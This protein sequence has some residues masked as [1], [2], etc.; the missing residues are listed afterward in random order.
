MADFDW[1]SA[2]K[3]ASQGFDWGSAA[4]A[5]PKRE[6]TGVGEALAK[7]TGQ[8]ITGGFGDEI[9]G[10]V[11]ALGARFLPESMGGGGDQAE[12]K[13]LLELY[14]QNRNTFREED[15]LAEHD[16][17]AAF[18]VGNIAGGAA[19]TPL[20][21]GGSASGLRALVKTG[22]LMGGANGL[23]TSG[24]DL[25][26]GEVGRAAFDTAVGAGVGAGAGAAGYGLQ[27]TLAGAGNRLA[28]GGA[29]RMAAAETK[30]TEMGEAQALEEVLS[31]SQKHATANADL[32]RQAERI[33]TGGIPLTPEQE[34][35]VKAAEVY[36]AQ[37]GLEKLPSSVAQSE[38]AAAA[39]EELLANQTGR[40]SGLAKELLKPSIGSDIK[41]LAKAYGEP[42]VANA[43]GGPAVGMLL[44]RT[45]MGKAVAS[46][47]S[48]PGNQAALAKT[49]QSMGS[50]LTRM[51]PASGTASAVAG[52]GA[53]P[54]GAAQS[55]LMEIPAIAEL[56]QGEDEDGRKAIVQ[57]LLERER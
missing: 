15:K 49:L 39:V 36:S 35:A 31:G 37:K 47:L 33:R 11:Q 53:G 55:G 32:N 43:V 38:S 3:P 1:G 50:G 18:T 28:S 21:P 19:L 10:A 27:K 54:V 29:K 34:A 22:A 57:A 12:K 9:N 56:F 23:G 20:L 4:R 14:R 52:R 48:R 2:A 17:G 25:T 30:A 40:A 7:G 46:R 6:K 42:L 16:Q 41:S 44:G 26:K 51:S 45:R 13:G 24:A 5:A 8:G